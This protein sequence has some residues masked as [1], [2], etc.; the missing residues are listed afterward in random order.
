[1]FELA[2]GLND[3]IDQEVHELFHVLVE[4]MHSRFGQRENFVYIFLETA[5]LGLQRFAGLGHARAE[6]FAMRR[7][8]CL[9]RGHEEFSPMTKRRNQRRSRPI[10]SSG[11]GIIR[12]KSN[13]FR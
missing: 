9:H 1:M 4:R 5:R 13:L 10:G 2:A 3:L 7:E 12:Q 11:R 8:E 6:A